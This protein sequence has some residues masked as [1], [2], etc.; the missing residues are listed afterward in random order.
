[1]S[2]L[3]FNLDEFTAAHRPVLNPA[4]LPKIK[5]IDLFCGAGGV[6]AGFHRARYAGHIIA[7]VVAC[8]NHDP[9]AIRSH[10]E[11]YPDCQHF[12]EDI[13]LLNVKKLPR[14]TRS[15]RDLFLL[16]AS[17][18]CTNF[19]NA[20]GGPRDAD[21][22]TLPNELFRYIRWVQPDVI[23]VEN[24]REFMSWG[25]LDANGKPVERKK[26][27]DYVKWYQT[28]E[29][30][31]Y[32]YSY[33]LLNSADYGAP[34]SRLR[35]F[36][37]FVRD[38]LPMVF[39]KPTHDRQGR[40]GLPKWEP[41]RKVLDL[42][43]VGESIFDRRYKSGKP[44][45]PYAKNTLRRIFAGL[46]KFVAAD[47]NQFLVKHYGGDPQH[48]AASLDGPAPTLTTIPHESLTTVQR[49]RRPLFLQKYMSNPPGGEVNHGAS[50]DVPAPTLAC[51]RTPGLVSAEFLIQYNGA[52]LPRTAH[53]LDKPAITLTQKDRL[54]LV[55]AAW[56]DN[57]T[58]NG[59]PSSV[60]GPC[61]TLVTDPRQHL[62]QVRSWMDNQFRRGDASSLEAP[63]GALTTVPKRNLCTAFLVNNRHG[64]TGHSLDGPAPT[65]CTGNHHFLLSPQYTNG[66]RSIDLPAPTLQASR[67]WQ[68]L[69]NWQ[70]GHAGSS[71]EKPCFTLI[72]TMGKRPPQIISAESI[73]ARSPLSGLP[74]F[75]PL[76][77]CKQLPI[78]RRIVLFMAYHGVADVFMR[79]LFIRELKR[80]Q[81]L[82]DDYVLH[83]TQ[84]DQKRFIGNAVVPH[85]VERWCIDFYV[86]YLTQMPIAA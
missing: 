77:H 66:P 86:E 50:L 75:V 34:Q 82:G 38:G 24:V 72:A 10:A 9:M 57:R 70:Y 16:W 53:S 8:V 43:Q 64:N 5:V 63:C 1:M 48:L 23:M 59:R 68:Y 13:R 6:T 45:K 37:M 12:T 14:K 21:S 20:K 29:K 69:V 2:N 36:G 19:S 81:G 28:I 55:R 4:G 32:R 84:E 18:E 15:S 60:H 41:V 58:I 3:L 33:R 27:V 61:S 73:R 67:R 30:M 46:E 74:V 56:I 44:K 52:P 17:C 40:N 35:Y 39:P 42:D 76:Y 85:V 62:V 51:Q 49:L 47:H 83:G 65:L 25:E 26:G 79:P 78:L 11:N 80:I 71:L 7:E 54:S 22:R 31:G